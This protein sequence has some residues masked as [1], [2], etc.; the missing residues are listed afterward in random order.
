MTAGG[1]SPGAGRY[2]RERAPG[3]ERGQGNTLI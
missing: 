1:P 2:I 3:E